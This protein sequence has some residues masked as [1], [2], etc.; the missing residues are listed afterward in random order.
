MRH[1]CNE[2]QL[3]SAKNDVL[4]NCPPQISNLAALG[5]TAR[6]QRLPRVGGHSTRAGFDSFTRKRDIELRLLSY[7]LP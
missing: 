1:T 2:G 4:H 7:Q 3:S 5:R 6:A